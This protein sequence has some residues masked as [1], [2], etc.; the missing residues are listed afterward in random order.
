MP[1]LPYGRSAGRLATP[2]HLQANPPRQLPPQDMISLD[3]QEQQAQ[4]VTWGW[5][6]SPG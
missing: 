1:A 5:V 4:R 3:A 6:R 2:V